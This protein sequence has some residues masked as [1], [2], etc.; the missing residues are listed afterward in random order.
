[1][2][3]SLFSLFLLV[4]SEWVL[5][6]LAACS[7]LSLTV[8]F[9]RW[10]NLRSQQKIG[11]RLWKDQAEKWLV[12]GLPETWRLQAPEL[13]KQYPCVE[14]RLM[15]SLSTR[16]GISTERLEKV[17]QGFL[18][19]ERMG[20]EHY[21][22]ILGTLGNSAPFIGLFGTVLGI[23]RAFSELDQA[24]G[25]SG[26][27]SVSGGLAEALVTTATGLLVA[28]PSAIAY[29]FYQRNIKAIFSRSQSLVG[30]MTESQEEV[31]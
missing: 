10:R 12:E 8:I 9:D 16:K 7:L 23:I 25:S 6:I 15:S 3:K 17:C 5:W 19:S 18:I 11:E 26:L 4:G 22:A 21:L 28:I 14:A 1:M 13:A 24:T 31:L 2:I 20:L 27:S 29:N 30:L